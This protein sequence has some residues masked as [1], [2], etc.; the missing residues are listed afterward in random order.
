MLA[1][2]VETEPSAFQLRVASFRTYDVEVILAVTGR[3]VIE[4]R[5]ASV[6]SGA[7]QCVERQ[8]R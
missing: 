6:I 3:D 1:H 5:A 7:D 8:R 2:L 4:D